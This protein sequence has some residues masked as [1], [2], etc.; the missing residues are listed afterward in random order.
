VGCC[1]STTPEKS[2]EAA[3]ALVAEVDVF[4]ITAMTACRG[5]PSSF[6][7]M[8]V[9]RRRFPTFVVSESAVKR[10]KRRQAM[11]IHSTNMLQPC[12]AAT[13][14]QLKRRSKKPSDDVTI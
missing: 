13:H 7:E 2:G 3:R 12:G 11:M 4:V 9:P 1:A 6:H 5:T 10:K 14:P 8:P